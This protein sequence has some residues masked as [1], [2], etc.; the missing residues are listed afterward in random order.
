M[1]D[2]NG[3]VLEFD[4]KMPIHVFRRLKM[5]FYGMD[6]EFD[7]YEAG[8]ILNC[9]PIYLIKDI[10]LKRYCENILWR[11]LKKDW[12]NVIK[13]GIELDDDGLKVCI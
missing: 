10:H 7:V 13:L 9:Y 12:L 11:N 1:S 4:S 8:W 2:F 5:W 6:V 3:D